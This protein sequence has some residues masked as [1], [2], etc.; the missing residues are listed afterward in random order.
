MKWVTRS[1]AR[2]DRVAC[3]WLIS[4]F[5]DKE[6][7]FL[8]VP[9]EDVL[10]VAKETGAIPFDMTGVELS[11]FVIDGREYCSFD[12]IMRKY[13]LNEEALKKMAE[14]VRGAD[15]RT[16]SPPPESVGLKA[17]ADGFHD[18]VENDLEKLKQEFPMYDALY[19][20]CKGKV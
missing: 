2:V 9:K 1:S 19:R 18:L 6:P 10:N 14:I 5:I 13:G 4:R 8:F 20:Y 12:S 15:V 7:E 3:P 17:I 16:Q 11:H